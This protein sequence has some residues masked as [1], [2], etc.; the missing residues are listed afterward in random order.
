MKIYSLYREQLVRASLAD[1]WKY[2]SNP[3]NLR[4][5][6]PREL[7]FRVV[8]ADLPDEIYPG[9]FIEYKVSPILRIPLTWVTEITHVEAGKM[10]A[11]EQR[12]GPYR[13]WSHKHFFRKDGRFTHMTDR[14]DYALP[15][16]PLA[17]V[18]NA[19]VVRPKLEH[20]FNF[21]KAV[22]D[23]LFSDKR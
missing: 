6:T 11:D 3:K 10:F 12:I 19:L 22:V 16:I 17:S 18:A 20:I 13:I 14:V 1:T 4:H 23:S 2:F 8:T 21:R 15:A 9:L 7:G 5:I